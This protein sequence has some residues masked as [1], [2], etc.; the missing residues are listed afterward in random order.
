MVPSTG[1]VIEVAISNHHPRVPRIMPDMKVYRVVLFL[2][3][4]EAA[5]EIPFEGKQVQNIPRPEMLMKGLSGR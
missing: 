5:S 3:F 2:S 1:G 4:V